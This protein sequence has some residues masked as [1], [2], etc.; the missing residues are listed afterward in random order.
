MKY[1]TVRGM[2]IH[3]PD[4]IMLKRISVSKAEEEMWRKSH[5]EHL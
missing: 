3:C 2:C 4:R 5:S 1:I